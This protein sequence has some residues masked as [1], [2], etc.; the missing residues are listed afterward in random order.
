MFRIRLTHPQRAFADLVLANMGIQDGPLVL[1]RDLRQLRRMRRSIRSIPA[2]NRKEQVSLAAII[3]KLDQA[4]E[5]C[6]E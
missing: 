4:E 6:S 2:L 5:S 3:R 1:L